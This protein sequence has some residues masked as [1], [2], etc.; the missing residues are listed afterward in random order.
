MI[1][2]I[3]SL[4]LFFT[5]SSVKAEKYHGDNYQ[6][7][8]RGDV[9]GLINSIEEEP[10]FNWD[11]NKIKLDRKNS[12]IYAIALIAKG[13]F[14]KAQK[15]IESAL[16]R[17]KK[18]TRLQKAFNHISFFKTDYQNAKLKLED[19]EKA[20]IELL[21]LVPEYLSVAEAGLGLKEVSLRKKIK[22]KLALIDNRTLLFPTKM[23][24]LLE[25]GMKAEAKAEALETIKQHKKILFPKT[26]DHYEL[27]HAYRSLA[28]LAYK[29]AKANP[30][31]Q[32]AK[33]AE[34]YFR[35]AE[36]NINRMQALWLIEDLIVQGAL[37]RQHKTE[38]GYIFPQ[39]IISQ[40]QRF[41]NEYQLLLNEL[42]SKKSL[43]KA[44]TH[45]LD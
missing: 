30:K 6:F 27:A 5:F 25:L 12:E 31:Q 24:Y 1:R 13:D 3:V 20:E 17:H 21:E 33:I 41:D 38:F 37:R 32:A 43:T 39:W 4:I 14:N 28:I 16:E 2:V 35:L 10:D 23:E 29:E 9:N 18:S 19:K 26:L 36:L 11:K 34:K 44:N 42:A 40:I 7:L 8:I 45:G 15:F 22:D